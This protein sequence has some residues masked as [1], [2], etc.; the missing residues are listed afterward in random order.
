MLHKGQIF[1]S[2]GHV[3]TFIV[4][5]KYFRVL[6]FLKRILTFTCKFCFVIDLKTCQFIF[7]NMNV[8]EIKTSFVRWVHLFVW[9]RFNKKI[10]MK[11][12]HS[13]VYFAT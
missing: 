7:Y 4:F 9:D 1:F 13:S 10:F 2:S 6:C 11:F 3:E 5:D 8:S 12:Y